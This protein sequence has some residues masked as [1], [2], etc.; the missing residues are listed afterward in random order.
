V[1]TSRFRVERGHGVDPRTGVSRGRGIEFAASHRLVPARTEHLDRPGAAHRVD[2]H[3]IDVE[4]GGGGHVRDSGAH[5]A[6]AD[7][8]TTLCHSVIV[9]VESPR[10]HGGPTV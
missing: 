4:T 5:R 9:P 1:S 10:R 3:E 7:H 8:R 6:A 2:F